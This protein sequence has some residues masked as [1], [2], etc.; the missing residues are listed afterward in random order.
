MERG[1][2]LRVP[3][4]RLPALV[5][6]STA[7]V[8]LSVAASTA[9]AD[10]TTW[11]AFGTGL[12]VDH[13]TQTNATNWNPT[14]TASMGVGSDPTHKLVV[15]GVFRTNSRFNEGTDMNLS[16]RFASGGFARGDWGVAFDLGPGLRLWENNQ[17]GT[18][19]LQGNITFGF[20]WGLQAAIGSDIYNLGGHPTSLGAYAVIEFDLLRFTL[21]RQGSTDRYWKIPL[22]AGGRVPPEGLE[23][24]H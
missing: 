2:E 11:L 8:A 7:G 4:S 24:E 12:A 16:V 3:R 21:M 1:T 6:A 20:P 19:P 18:F 23:R 9:R 22:P 5:L 10:V 13:S 14:I 15:G 17:Y